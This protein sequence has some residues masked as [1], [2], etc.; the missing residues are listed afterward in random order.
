MALIVNADIPIQRRALARGS[1]MG[2]KDPIG[3]RLIGRTPVRLFDAKREPPTVL[4][5]GD[6]V[7]FRA[8]S[9]NEYRELTPA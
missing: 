3:W 7:R 9:P 5:V 6:V 2:H 8:I 1:R 4:S